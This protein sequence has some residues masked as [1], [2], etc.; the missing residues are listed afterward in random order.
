VAFLA[1]EEEDGGAPHLGCGAP[2]TDEE[3][4]QKAPEICPDSPPWPVQRF[5]NILL[6]PVL[7]S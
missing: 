3:Q 4:R 2:S 5:C 1:G 7:L 6:I